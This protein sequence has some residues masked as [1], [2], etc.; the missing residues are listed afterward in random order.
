MIAGGD[1][2]PGDP[3]KIV[4]LLRSARTASSR[5][6]SILARSSQR[7]GN[8][9]EHWILACAE[10]SENSTSSDQ[11]LQ[12]DCLDTPSG[13]LNCFSGTRDARRPL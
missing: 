5:W 9:V 4:Q 10:M 11:L 1:V 3:I 2:S 6:C 13:A 12:R 7:K 8:P